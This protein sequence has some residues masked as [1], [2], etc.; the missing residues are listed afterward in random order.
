MWGDFLDFDQTQSLEKET[1]GKCF[2]SSMLV[3][4]HFAVGAIL[5]GIVIKHTVIGVRKTV[6][7]VFK[8]RVGWTDVLSIYLMGLE[9]EPAKRNSDE[10]VWCIIISIHMYSLYS[11]INISIN[12]S[13]KHIKTYQVGS[14]NSRPPPV[15]WAP[16][17]CGP[18]PVELLPPC[19]CIT[20]P[21]GES[22]I[23][24]AWS[25]SKHQLGI[26]FSIIDVWRLKMV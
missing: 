21:G 5:C 12:I 6:N 19:W 24:K 15:G 9:P 16:H 7:K 20:R 13:I 8:T 18:R 11:G 2:V 14:K 4:V 10:I 22:P 17:P 26:Y 1:L 25:E 23:E 3:T